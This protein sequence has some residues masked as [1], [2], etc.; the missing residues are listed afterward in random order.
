MVYDLTAHTLSWDAA[1]KADDYQFQFKPTTSGAKW[2]IAY[3]GTDNHCIFDPG[4]SAFTLRC[5]G[6]NAEGYGGWSDE[7]NV[8]VP[9]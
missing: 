3:E 1:P 6:H 9:T 8:I 5:R 4:L 7:L 2:E